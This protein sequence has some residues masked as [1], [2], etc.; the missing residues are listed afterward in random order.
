MNIKLTE[1]PLTLAVVRYPRR[2][3]ACLGGSILADMPS[4]MVRAFE[5]HHAR[6]GVV[7]DAPM[8]HLTVSAPRGVKLTTRAWR[9]TL[10]ATLRDLGASMHQLVWVAYRHLR[11]ATDHVHLLFSRYT[12]H[13]VRIVPNMSRDL[14]DLGNRLSHRLRLP[15]PFPDIKGGPVMI[16][17]P[18]RAAKT[19]ERE[20]A[21]DKGTIGSRI[22][23]C[24]SV[25]RPVTYPGFVASAARHGV[26]IQKRSY[27]NGTQG[28]AYSLAA[29]KPTSLRDFRP[30]AWLPGGGIGVQFTLKGLL[31]RLDLLRYLSEVPAQL[32]V[33][34]LFATASASAGAQLD[35][36]KDI[37][38]RRGKNHQSDGQRRRG[39]RGALAAVT[40]AE[41]DRGPTG[42]AGRGTGAGSRGVEHAVEEA[43]RVPG[44]PPR[45]VHRHGD[46]GRVDARGD[47]IDQVGAVRSGRADGA[48]GNH[49]ARDP[50]ALDG[51]YPL[52]MV[53]TVGILSR[54]TQDWG[55]ALSLRF[56]EGG[57]F[58]V[59]A[60]PVPLMRNRPNARAEILACE[61]PGRMHQLADAL[62]L[63][64][65][66][67]A[68]LEEQQTI[69]AADDNI[70]PD[71]P[72]QEEE[73]Q[74]TEP[75]YDV[76]G[77]GF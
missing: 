18:V 49:V 43:V 66:P 42:S 64:V 15:T 35:L 53:E 71:G 1:A 75:H 62:G 27:R 30:P 55:V 56:E 61:Y 59:S 37:N 12:I 50:L 21:T 26:E 52:T 40:Q 31:R 33:I 74:P 77:P 68:G 67:A 8:M 2:G 69:V 44:K 7:D 72:A 14:Y 32:A 41:G 4:R 46:K 47:R 23:Q 63:R 57:G 20:G 45:A 22:N 6:V 16:E 76:D 28:L 54:L 17:A 38:E 19:R 34:K 3:G 70:S 25:D 51:P 36:W 65:D 10:S 9:A 39:S 60:G 13:G 11:A 24:L 29:P 58:L 5:A 48:D 73:D